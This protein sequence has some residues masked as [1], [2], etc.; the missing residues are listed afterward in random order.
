MPNY[1]KPSDAELRMQLT[2]LQ[3]WVTQ[4]DGTETPFQNPYWNEHREGIFVDVVS[5]EPLFSSKDKFASG[6][7]WPSFSKPLVA[8]NVVQE[9]D[10]SLGMTR[11]EVA[12]KHAHSHL[13]HKFNDGPAPTGLRYCTDS[14][15]LRFIP[16]DQLEAKGYGFFKSQFD[17]MKAEMKK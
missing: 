12:S 7:G 14:A 2:P 17:G 3:Y 9:V 8:G 4:E 10:N 1:K 15:S 5:G 6:T 13:G 16:K 11:M